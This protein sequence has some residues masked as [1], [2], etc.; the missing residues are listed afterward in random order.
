MSPRMP[1]FVQ[2][3]GEQNHTEFENCS[4]FVGVGR[5]P[6]LSITFDFE[7]LRP[8]LIGSALAVPRPFDLVGA[9]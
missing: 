9:G 8:L 2:F 5:N 3:Y 1:M 6:A 7:F 4:R